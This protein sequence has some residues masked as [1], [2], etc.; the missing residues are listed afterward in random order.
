MAIGK[1]VEKASSLAWNLCMRTFRGT[2][3]RTP[4]ACF[5]KDI[6]YREGN[7]GIHTLISKGDPEQARFL[8]GK[9]DPTNPRHIWILD[10]FNITEKDLEKMDQ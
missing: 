6:A 5:S 4:G 1:D 7:I 9:Y 8:T 10:Q 3:G 2:T